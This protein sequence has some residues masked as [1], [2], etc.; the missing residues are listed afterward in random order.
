MDSLFK[1]NLLKH[2]TE[3]ALKEGS[4]SLLSLGGMKSLI[5]N[6][7]SQYVKDTFSLD[8]IIKSMDKNNDGK[9]TFDEFASV[10]GRLSGLG[11]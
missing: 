2:F 8:T 11:Q 10:M 5:Q 3:Y 9:V 4:T 7:F 6:Q 1:D